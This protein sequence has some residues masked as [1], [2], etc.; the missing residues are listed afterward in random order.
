MRNS[1]KLI[2]QNFEKFLENVDLAL[3]TLIS[4]VAPAPAPAPVGSVFFWM[5][6]PAPAP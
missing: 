5:L 6:A 3:S 1:G 4:V 2:L